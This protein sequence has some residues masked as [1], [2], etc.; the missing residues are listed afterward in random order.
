MAVLEA[1][2]FIEQN[3]H[4]LYSTAQ[5]LS[6]ADYLDTSLDC[7]E[8]RL[9]GHYSDGLGNHWQDPH[10]VR[11]HNQGQVNYPWLS[12]GMWF[13]TQ[14]RRWGLLREDPDY[15]TVA[16]RVQQLALYR[17]AATALGIDVPAGSVDRRQGVGWQRSG[18]LCTQLQT[19]LAGRFRASG[20]QSLTENVSMLR[21]LLINDTARKVGRLKSAL[22]EAG[23]DV[24]DES[25]LTIDL[26][27]RVENRWFWSVA[28]NRAR[29]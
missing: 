22:T 11:F 28:T 9:L 20:C 4:N 29:S 23:F 19:S 14:F 7:I 24:I 18:R 3:P 26:P 6:G 1:S 5:L 10:P 16:S 2:R 15:L 27:A 13:M 17:Q 21:I 25:G 12:D 8:P